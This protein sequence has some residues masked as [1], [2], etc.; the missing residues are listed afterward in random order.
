VV[1][2]D[3]IEGL[4]EQTTM[5]HAWSKCRGDSGPSIRPREM[6]ALMAI[7]VALRPDLSFEVGGPRI[8]RHIGDRIDHPYVAGLECHPCPRL[9]SLPTRL[10]SA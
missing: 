10:L 5:P 4:P 8:T 9:F 7:D 3:A 1:R 2:H 6:D